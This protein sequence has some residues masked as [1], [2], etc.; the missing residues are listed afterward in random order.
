M[1]SAAGASPKKPPT[2][3]CQ[4]CPRSFKR[5]E[6]VQ[7][8][9][10][11]HTKEAPFKCPCGR[12]FARRDLLT[13]H[14]RSAHGRRMTGR[15]RAATPASPD[16]ESSLSL[17]QDTTDSGIGMLQTPPG[18]R[19]SP[20]S[21]VTE[22]PLEGESTAAEK[23]G[24]IGNP[25]ERVH[26]PDDDSIQR[27]YG[28][29]QHMP[30]ASHGVDQLPSSVGSVPNLE[31]VL[32]ASAI[33]EPR[34]LSSSFFQDD[35]FLDE[36][37]VFLDDFDLSFSAN[38]P[39]FQA[40][41]WDLGVHFGNAGP[42]PNHNAGNDT[43]DCAAE[44][45]DDY[46]PSL[47]RFGSPLP[48]LEPHVLSQARISGARESSRPPFPRKISAE[49][50]RILMAKLQPWEGVLS[51]GFSLPSRHTL[52]RF[53]D[54]CIH[55]LLEHLPCVHVPT[56]S[57][58]DASIELVLAMAAIGAEFRFDKTRALDL[59]YAARAI[60][61]SPMPPQCQ[62][63][64]V[65]ERSTTPTDPVSSTAADNGVVQ[66]SIES[67]HRLQRIQAILA[68]MVL[69]SWS[70]KD[71][72]REAMSLQSMCSF[73]V[74]EDMLMD[75]DDSPSDY[76]TDSPLSEAQW[77][78]WARFESRRRT[79]IM[80]FSFLNLQS[81]A[82]NIPPM[83]LASEVGGRLPASAR[84]WKEPTAQQWS[85]AYKTTKL[86]QISFQDALAALFREPRSSPSTPLS[87]VSNYA[88][89]HA[90]LQR[91]LNLRQASHAGQLDPNA[92]TELS[93][94]LSL[95][96]RQWELSPES[97]VEPESPNGPIAFNSTPLLRLAWIRLQSDLGPCRHLASRDPML[98]ASAFRQSPPLRRDPELLRSVL[99]AAY[100]LSV[101][102]RMGV[103]FV[104]RTQTLSWSVQHSLCNFDCAIFLSKWFEA[105]A[106]T[107]SEQPPTPEEQALIKMIR[108]MIN[109]S[110]LFQKNAFSG[111]GREDT[112]QASVHRLST[113]VARIWAEIYSGNHIWEI[114]N[115]IGASLKIYADTLEQTHSPISFP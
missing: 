63:S 41:R 24:I 5:L 29:S 115:T 76:I 58:E 97:N 70:S 12:A 100:A 104:S 35:T 88:L 66:P 59:F 93:R 87:T 72:V 75:D 89:I 68:I 46:N 107:V 44:T 98:I 14:E 109:E 21:R 106:L 91:I 86:S 55:G 6:H 81:L 28:F 80:A 108:T 64:I 79:K 73:L 38:E 57:I 56:L 47:S 114:V 1:A 77:R 50:Y 96:Q 34:G 94:S 31:E 4:Y 17:A 78:R 105:L 40:T 69:G 48:S 23:T 111:I 19:Q 16:T 102:V 83:V 37:N 92:V 62:Q 25:G 112:W 54:G 103:T 82:Y 26:F 61:M 15:R 65:S 22:A 67:Q 39:L 11:T 8:H 42:A 113:A 43:Y 32:Q 71:L 20:T 101:P 84:E 85:R 51:N 2:F 45:S 27:I 13:R 9:E 3:A 74:R 10:R 110:G 30:P 52:S 33:L 49:E 18:T 95:W 99:Q 60:I 7:R 53:L 36:H 90:I